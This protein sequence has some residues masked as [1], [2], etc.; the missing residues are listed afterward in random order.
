MKKYVFSF[1]LKLNEL[2]GQS[3]NSTCM[4]SALYVKN[5]RHLHTHTHTL[6][7]CWSCSQLLYSD[8]LSPVLCRLGASQPHQQWQGLCAS[9]AR[10]E[11]RAV[12]L[13]LN[14]WDFL[15]S[16]HNP[17]LR[18]PGPSVL[19]PSQPPARHWT[20]AAWT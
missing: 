16:Q 9:P 4:D 7:L 12:S 2:F 17:N 14:I 8:A 11:H 3:S 15:V 20:R 5:D 6:P 13:R 10:E 1:Y 18:S 19:M